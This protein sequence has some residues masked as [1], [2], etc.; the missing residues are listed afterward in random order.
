MSVLGVGVR[1][2]HSILFNFVF[3]FALINGSFWTEHK[4]WSRSLHDAIN[5]FEL[6]DDELFALFFSSSLFPYEVWRVIVGLFLC[7]YIL[8]IIRLLF[9]AI[10]IQLHSW[11]MFNFAKSNRQMYSVHNSTTSIRQPSRSTAYTFY[12]SFYFYFIFW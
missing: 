8:H 6:V 4:Q 1:C 5:W 11:F 3:F 7:F 10:N 12:F 2:R 9:C